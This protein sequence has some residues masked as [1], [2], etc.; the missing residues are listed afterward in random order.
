MH[1]STT[2][3]S[4]YNSLESTMLRNKN[5]FYASVKVNVKMYSFLLSVMQ[6]VFQMTLDLYSMPGNKPVTF[7]WPGYMEVANSS[8]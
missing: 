2:V 7:P 4:F 8:L 3:T 5:T 1:F 6:L